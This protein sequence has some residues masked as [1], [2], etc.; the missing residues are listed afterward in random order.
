MYLHTAYPSLGSAG[1][2]NPSNNTRIMAHSFACNHSAPYRVGVFGRLVAAAAVVGLIGCSSGAGEP[3]PPQVIGDAIGVEGAHEHGV[4]SL[5]AAVDGLRVTMDFEMPAETL[6]G[7]EHMPSTEE[8]I[9]TVRAQVERMRVEAAS[10]IAFPEASGCQ[11]GTVEVLRSPDLEAAAAAMEADAHEHGD[12]EHD[13][14]YEHNEDHDHEHG[15]DYEAEHQRAHDEGIEHDHPEEH[16]PEGGDDHEHS[17]VRLRV[18]MECTASPE[19]QAATLR[20]AE[21]LPNAEQ[22]DL[23][24]ITSMGQAAARVAAN[25]EFSF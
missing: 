9:E 16:A 1:Q 6:F 4:L 19:G 2:P 18:V 20:I 17:E 8:E 7:F 23:T 21:L 12:H 11:V 5:G 15:D 14:D 22:V 10:A 13:A 25:T 3:S 24:V